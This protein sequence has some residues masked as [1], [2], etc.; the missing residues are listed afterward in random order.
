M[1]QYKAYPAYK[2]SGV[3]WIG[4][5]PEEW[6]TGKLKHLGT[7]KGGSG[8]PTDMQ[9]QPDNELP[10]YKVGDLSKS[11]DNISLNGSSNTISRKDAKE[12]GATVFP[13]NTISWAKIGAA[14]FLNRRRISKTA[15]CLDNNMTGFVVD[16]KKV[17]IQYAFYL[18][19][20]I[21][22]SFFARPGAVPSLS[23]GE[24]SAI[25]IAIPSYEESFSIAAT[26]DRE[27]SR[28]DALIQKKTRFIDEGKA[29]GANH[30]CGHQGA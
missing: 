9:G 25:P 26:L 24:Q 23:E 16:S 15:C 14:L 19:N 22:F 27:T 28:I 6:K 29:S 17:P 8:F 1:S 5:V 21:D 4:Q 3:E 13:E 10:F 2:D 7:L 18:M 30:P 12:L 11:R 20:A